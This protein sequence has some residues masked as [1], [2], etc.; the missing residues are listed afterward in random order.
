M[1]VPQ[2]LATAPIPKAKM[3]VKNPPRRVARLRAVQLL[4]QMEM[5]KT[6]PDQALMM[7]VTDGEK[8]ALSPEKS[9]DRFFRHLLA[10]SA[11]DPQALDALIIS[12]LPTNWPLARL[13]SVLRAV[14]RLAVVEFKANPEIPPL[15]TISE[16]VAIAHAFFGGKE[17]AMVNGV[18]H[19]LAQQ[20]R[21]AE[22]VKT[23]AMVKTESAPAAE[24][25][26]HAQPH[27]DAP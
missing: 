4:Y 25:E 1:T 8:D 20:I 2:G 23:T 21:P 13:D 7:M 12:A 10:A 19:H 18:L 17:P 22:M 6:A 15:I 16:Y 24:A 26:P 27:D 11:V 3:G 9:D 14:L 5:T